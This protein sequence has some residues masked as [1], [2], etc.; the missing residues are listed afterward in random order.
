MRQDKSNGANPAIA[1]TDCNVPI[2][3]GNFYFAYY[4]KDKNEGEDYATPVAAGELALIQRVF[5]E[6]TVESK[7]TDIEFG[8]PTTAEM[9]SNVNLRNRG[10]PP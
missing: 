5:I 7:N 2:A 4:G 1:L 6:A 8:G 9:S 3:A 10:L